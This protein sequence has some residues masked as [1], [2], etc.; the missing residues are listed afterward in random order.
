MKKDFWDTIHN[1]KKVSKCLIS[2]ND[3]E[4]YTYHGNVILVIKV[5]RASRSE[6]PVYINN[7]VYGGTYRRDHEGDYSC[8][9]DEVKAMIGDSSE[10]S[11]DQEALDL[12]ARGK[13]LTAEEVFDPESIKAYRIRYNTRHEGSA[14]SELD[15]IDFLVQIGA[16]N[17][18]S[19]YIRPTVAGLLMFGTERRISQVYPDYF[20]DYQEHMDETPLHDAV[21]EALVNCL[22]NTDFY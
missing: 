20:L 21:R 16:A 19:E 18:E 22:V 4:E 9:E 1:S 13:K 15:D 14:W 7:D 17:D 2:E 6:K 8:T 11:P 5:P 3:T 10:K 12:T